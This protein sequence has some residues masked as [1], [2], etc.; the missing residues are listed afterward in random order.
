MVSRRS[1]NGY[2]R[3]SDGGSPSAAVRISRRHRCRRMEVIGGAW[4][5]RGR[6]GELPV[7]SYRCT[8]DREA[9]P[10]GST[11]RPSRLPVR[12]PHVQAGR[13]QV[14]RPGTSWWTEQRAV[15]SASSVPDLTH[16]GYRTDRP[17]RVCNTDVNNLAPDKGR[18]WKVVR[19]KSEAARRPSVLKC[20]LQV[21]K[22]HG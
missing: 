21:Q 17:C 8:R 6:P 20:C 3:R 7:L 13:A 14:R 2:R 4:A 16:P 9:D 22:S 11:R 19:V 18:G 12:C 5:A 1:A 10:A 15:K